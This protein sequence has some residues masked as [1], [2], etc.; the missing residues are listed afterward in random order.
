MNDHTKVS[1]EGI[2]GVKSMD[3]IPAE[4]VRKLLDYLT[5][6]ELLFA[7]T[8]KSNLAHV[9]SLREDRMLPRQRRSVYLRSES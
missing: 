2:R 4:L 8:C 3:R 6:Q 7:L 5:G 1:I 9:K